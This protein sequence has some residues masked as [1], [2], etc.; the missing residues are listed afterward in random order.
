MS[1]TPRL[2]YLPPALAVD[3]VRPA[4]A[5]ASVYRAA[6]YVVPAAFAASDIPTSY[7]ADTPLPTGQVRLVR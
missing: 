2:P 1:D 4:M 3:N 6:G 7:A 5:S